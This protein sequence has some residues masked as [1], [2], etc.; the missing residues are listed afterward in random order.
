MGRSHCC[1][2][3]QGIAVG[4]GGPELNQLQD[5]PDPEDTAQGKI[6][7]VCKKPPGDSPLYN[8]EFLIFIPVLSVFL[9]LLWCSWKLYCGKVKATA[10]SSPLPWLPHTRPLSKEQ[11]N[12]AVL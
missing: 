11:C 1:Y 9:L 8:Q 4:G 3:S 12:S 7:T 10:H 6:A 2:Q 5:D